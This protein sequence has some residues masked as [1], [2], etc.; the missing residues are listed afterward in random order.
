MVIVSKED[1]V[2]EFLDYLEKERKID[3]NHVSDLIKPK[4]DLIPISI[5][6]TK[7]FTPFEAVV[8]FLRENSGLKF[9]DIAAKFNKNVSTIITTYRRIRNLKIDLVVS[10]SKY[11]IP[12]SYFEK[13]KLTF[14][15][16]LVLY[17]RDERNLS[18][19]E[20]AVLLQRD[21]RTIWTVYN[22]AKKKGVN[23]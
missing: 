22:R 14:F 10:S 4:L 9:K 18:Y 3:L 8:K 21:D 23:K 7:D 12:I 2:R 1:L 17:L 5:F 6:K 13:K 11:D 20:V 16:V 19:H 15:E